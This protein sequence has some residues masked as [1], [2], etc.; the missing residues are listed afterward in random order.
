MPV[1]P[2]AFG[3]AVWALHDQEKAARAARPVDG[4]PAAGGASHNATDAGTISITDPDAFVAAAVARSR[5]RLEQ[6][7]QGE[8]NAGL[9]NEAMALG[10]LVGGELLDYDQTF[11]WLE[12]TAHE[13]WP[14]ADAG[15]V[16]GTVRSGL[17][18][19]M[20][21][22]LA[23]QQGERLALATPFT[24]APPVAREVVVDPVTG[25]DVLERT[26][27][28]PRDTGPVIRGELDPEPPPAYLMRDDGRHLF[29]AGKVNGLIGE[30]ESGKTWVA[31]LAVAQALQAGESVL[32]LDFE[33][34]VRGVLERIKS[35]GVDD[36]YL[37]RLTYIGP[38]ENLHGAAERDL[39]EAMEAAQ[40]TL[41]VVDGYNAAMT[42]LGLDLTNNTEVTA[43]SLRVLRPMARTG[44]CVITIDHVTKSKD[45]RGSYAIGAQ[46]KRADVDGCLVIV[47][48]NQPFGR[49]QVGRLKL[50]VS[51]DRPG[52]VRA[53]S[54]ESKIAGEAV[55]K[56][57]PTSGAVD[58]SVTRPAMSAT[59]RKWLERDTVLMSRVS[60]FLTACSEPPTKTAIKSAVTGNN[61]GVLRAVEQLVKER[62][63]GVDSRGRI[64][65]VKPYRQDEDP[66]YDAE[67]G[68]SRERPLAAPF[69]PAET[70]PERPWDVPYRPSGTVAPSVPPSP[71]PMGG[72]G[73]EGDGG[74]DAADEVA[75]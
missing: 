49:G 66:L 2:D 21:Q 28:W 73:D 34:T 8:R 71:L 26:S 27:W 19:G 5:E 22:P 16:R 48:V 53:V 55:L 58:A 38:D 69:T 39:R 64:T 35:L 31:L 52:F 14:D 42:L 17:T 74:P 72:T 30:S 3:L 43:F 56:S 59:G 33:D 60:E 1:A 65:H 32:Y 63:A 67:T 70:V 61:E 6:L 4:F 13:L 75:A 37:A 29:Y 54:A 10:H 57:D 62:Y 41:V 11:D 36:R 20:R 50:T 15:N 46:A 24:A 7:V 25:E 45:G 44:A 51:K 12:Q 9:N 47:E 18:A 40:P 68:Q 23:W